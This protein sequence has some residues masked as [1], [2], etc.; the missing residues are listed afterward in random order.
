MI[1][2]APIV[3]AVAGGLLA[4]LPDRWARLRSIGLV[5]AAALAAASTLLLLGRAATG[6]VAQ[7]QAPSFLPPLTLQL[8][9]EPAG[10][11]FAAVVAGLWML[12]TVQ[13]VVHLRGEPTARR[14]FLAWFATLAALTGVAYAADLLTLLVAYEAFSLLTYLLIVQERTPR[15]FAAGTRYLVYVLAGGSA[16]LAGVLIVFASGVPLTFVPGGVGIGA[17]GAPAVVAF[18]AFVAGFGVKAALMPLH[19]WVA[20]AHPAAPAPVSALLSG[21]MVAAGGWGLLR[22]VHGTFGVEAL[23]GLG[24]S[25]PFAALAAV[26]VLAAAL[27]ATR[28][29]DLK[30][31]LAYSTVSQMGYWTLAIA[32]AG[33]VVTAAGLVHLVHHAFLKGAL[34]FCAGVWIHVA[35]ARRLD[36]LR[37]MGRRTPWTAAAFTLAA[38]SMMGVPPLS[39]FVAKWWLGVGMLQDG[40]PWA[41]AVLLL[42]ALLA[43]AYLLPVVHALYLEAPTE[44]PVRARPPLALVVPSVAAAATALVF[45]LAGHLPGFPL[46]LAE[47]AVVAL[48]GGG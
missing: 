33:P 27:L 3:A 36:E 31:R 1:V 6:G 46:D 20:E 4:F 44:V 7:V 34:F 11:L 9:A 17:A 24:L 43:A 12:A 48:T 23:A 18:V 28:E 5:G 13:A 47:R 40:A 30:R 2:L 37:G 16:V 15:A 10:A 26:T 41:L 35:G 45:G 32:L 39:G 14:F 42:G 21:V 38:L 25:T 29:P 22:V 19:G 8:R